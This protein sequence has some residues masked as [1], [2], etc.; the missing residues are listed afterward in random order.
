MQWNPRRWFVAFRC[1]S[2]QPVFPFD[3][4]IVVREPETNPADAYLVTSDEGKVFLSWTAERSDGQGRN[5]FIAKVTGDGQQVTEIRQANQKS[6][7]GHGGE[8][9]AKFDVPF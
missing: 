6:I 1:L 5:L 7:S 2:L 3:Q 8:N 9:L 4:P